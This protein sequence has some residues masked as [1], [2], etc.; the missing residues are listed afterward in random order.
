MLNNI[1]YSVFCTT[2]YIFTCESVVSDVC[3]PNVYVWARTLLDFL[4]RSALVVVASLQFFA[5][6][7]IGIGR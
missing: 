1:D 6:L 4:F 3:G 5:Q 7:K 2:R